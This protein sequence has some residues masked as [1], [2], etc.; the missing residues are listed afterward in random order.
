M[1]FFLIQV[2]V[3]HV[4]PLISFSYLVNGESGYTNTL[5]LQQYQQAV[6]IVVL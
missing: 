4:N 1:F 6:D 2:F 3:M 5:C